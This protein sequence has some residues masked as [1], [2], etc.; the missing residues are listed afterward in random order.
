[1]DVKLNYIDLSNDP[2]NSNIVI[3]QKNVATDFDEL[4]VAWTVIRNCGKGCNHPFIF[5]MEM[6][7][8]A[9]DSWGNFT[10][11]MPAQNGQLYHM[12]SE[13]SGNELSYK[14]PGA[15]NKEVQ[16]LNDLQKGAIGA[17]I[18]KDGKLLAKK[19]AIAPGQKSVFQFKPTLFIG[20]ASQIVEGQIMNSAVISA[21]NT[22]LSLL[23]LASADIVMTGGGPGENA[24]AFDFKL[25]NVVMA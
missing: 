2:S 20:V 8:S 25:E 11:Q 7:V 4:S 15:S 19:S 16:V 5:P 10:P 9:N 24:T 6:A 3:F 18:Y 22:E 17:N 23:G 13:S 14:G 1:M 21:V 12:S